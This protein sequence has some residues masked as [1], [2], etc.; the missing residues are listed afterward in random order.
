[1]LSVMA[2]RQTLRFFVNPVQ[3]SAARESNFL[4]RCVRCL[5]EFQRNIEI[6]RATNGSTE[7]LEICFAQFLLSR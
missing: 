7:H 3:R 6:S 2:L 1:M 4:Y 5:L